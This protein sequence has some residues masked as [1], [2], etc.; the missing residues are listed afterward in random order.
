[1][2]VKRQKAIISLINEKAIETQKELVRA[3]LDLGFKVTQTTISR[4]IKELGLVKVPI[5]EGSYKYGLS[6]SK[7]SAGDTIKRV[8]RVF[9]DSVISI[10]ASENLIVLRSLPGTAQGV[11]ACIDSLK[12][13]E[14]M[15]T[16]GG[17]DTILV[18]IRSKDAT[19]DV[20]K[21]F[22]SL[23]RTL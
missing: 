22:E 5:P 13:E 2:K 10:E 11:A 21:R 6:T 7:I 9:E 14:I 12:W 17:D 18:I 15:G 20:V 23:G 4:D 16:I 1:M 8:R 19:G 3:L